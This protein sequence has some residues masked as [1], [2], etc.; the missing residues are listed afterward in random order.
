MTSFSTPQPK[1]LNQQITKKSATAAALWQQCWRWCCQVAL[2]QPSLLSYLEPLIRLVRPTFRAHVSHAKLVQIQ[3]HGN[4]L[5]L[6]LRPGGRWQGFIPGQHLQLVL[7]INGRAISRTF[8]ISSSLQ[9]FLEQGLI[10]LTIQQQP[11][12][13][14]S[15]QLQQ[16]SEPTAV[17]YSLP[18]LPIHL[19]AAQGSFTLSQH[20]PA[21]LLAAGSGITPI[22]AMLT[23]I[24]RLTQPL[25][26]IYSYRGADQLLFAESWRELQQKFPLLQ[27]Q[28]I[29]TQSRG[30]VTVA[31][32]TAW[33]FQQ[34]DSQIY[35]CGPTSFSQS[36]LHQL[37][38]L[39]V[40]P[41]NIKQESFGLGAL[42]P[43]NGAQSLHPIR[44]T[45][46]AQQ[47]TV[48]SGDGSLLQSLEAA[49]LDPAYG[50]RRGICMQCLCQK[51]QGVVRNLVTG[52]TSDAGPGQI[53][54]CISQPLSAVELNFV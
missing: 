17:V 8:S 41:A 9:L 24:T 49:G 38:L 12:G 35:V 36:W 7:E 11:Q 16:L 18:Q 26:L 40:P 54:L 48:Q 23:S 50:C 37:A 33:L 31:E 47:L 34:P 25:R 3:Q 2:V 14:I 19:S 45:L 29:D 39:K 5:H 52:E 21:L 53:Q 42:R 15:N 4:F 51:S 1:R 13:V 28:L 10:T 22:H 30:R 27:V 20:Q 46:A 32:V 44:V 43:E 6:T